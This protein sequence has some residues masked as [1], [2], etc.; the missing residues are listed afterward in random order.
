MQK[1]N[2]AFIYDVPNHEEHKK[3]IIEL[4][5]KIPQNKFDEIS[6]TDWNLPP[7][8]QKDWQHYFNKNI[9]TYFEDVFK[10]LIN[11]KML[12]NNEKNYLFKYHLN[13]YS[14]YSKFLNRPER[15]WLASLI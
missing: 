6:H 7:T 5:K 12:N 13:I 9:Y 15:K 4:I 1:I 3:I 14:K 10:D 8:M 11:F 2:S